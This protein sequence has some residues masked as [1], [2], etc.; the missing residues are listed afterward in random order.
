MHT[1]NLARV[2]LLLGA[3]LFSTGGAAIK[4]VSYSGWQVASLR[5]LVACLVL[6]M[7]WPNARRGW[8][9]GIVA[10]GAAYAAT[11]ILFSLANKLT[12]AANSI[13][14]QSTA[15]LYLLVLGPWL[16]R[17]SVQRRDLVYMAV[18]GLGLL[19]LLSGQESA[20][21]IASNPDLG[22]LLAVGAGITWALTVLGLRYLARTS[23][24]GANPALKAVLAGNVLAFIAA[25][26]AAWPMAA[27]AP[28]DW[29]MIIYLG[30]AQIALAYVL[31]TTG[32]KQ[33]TA[34]EASLLLL[35]EP[36]LSPVWAWIVHGERPAAMALA[37]G[38]VIV[39]ASAA[40][41]LAAE[42]R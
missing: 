36:V 14:L 37:G 38:C 30:A 39:L 5:S 20:T 19:L 40:R 15:P 35:L 7:V 21:R 32:L 26:A 41:A 24:P 31:V 18:I 16:L 9:A 23:L 4:L 3:A 11:L 34:L 8:N 22:N 42:R 27:G 12:T 25:G 2:Q 28:V 33:V 10:V 6:A 1:G 29:M 17:E 13:F